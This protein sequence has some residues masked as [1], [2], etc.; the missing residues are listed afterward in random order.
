MRFR[1]LVPVFILSCIIAAAASAAEAGAASH[2]V[3]LRIRDGDHP[4][5]QVAVT[6]R[7]PDGEHTNGSGFELK[8]DDR[9]I[10]DFDLP[11]ESFWLTVR[12]V[13]PDY[14][15]KEFVIPANARELV[16]W[17]VRPREWRREERR[18]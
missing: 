2:R 6:V 18:R 7:Y 15:G 14:V 10:V 4:A 8:T 11:A 9:G 12:E 1:V 3:R 17:E 16:S 13:N 5:K